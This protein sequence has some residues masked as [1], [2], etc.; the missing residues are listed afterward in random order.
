MQFE[1][2]IMV[3]NHKCYVDNPCLVK[4]DKMIKAYRTWYSQ[5]YS[6]NSKSF[7]AAKDNLEW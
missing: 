2:D 4:E 1:R 3:W 6:Q 7:S 5:F